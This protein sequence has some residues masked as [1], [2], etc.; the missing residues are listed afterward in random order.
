MAGFQE[1]IGNAFL[2]L[3]LGLLGQMASLKEKSDDF[4]TLNYNFSKKR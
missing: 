3:S 1:F 4:S 2:W